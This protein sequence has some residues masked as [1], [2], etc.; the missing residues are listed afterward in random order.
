[1]KIAF[2]VDAGNITGTGHLMEVVSLIKSLGRRIEF[3]AIAI[4]NNYPLCMEKLKPLVEH[5]E[6][7]PD[8]IPVNNE[9]AILLDFLKKNDISVIVMDLLDKP[10]DYYR[11]LSHGIERTYVVLD[12]FVHKEIPAA[13]VVNFNIAQSQDYYKKAVLY[14]TEYLIGPKYAILDEDLYDIWSE[15]AGC[16][17][18]VKTIFVNQGGSDPYGLTVKSLEALESLNLQ[19]EII[20]VSGGAVTHH[21]KREL[22]RLKPLLKGN[23]KFY[24]NISQQKFFELLAISDIALTAAGNTLYEI[25]FFGIPS[26]VICHHEN[27]NRVASE[28]EKQ[29]AAINLGIGSTIDRKKILDKIQLLLMN[30]EKRKQLSDHARSLVDGYGTTRFTERIIETL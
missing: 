4:V 16:R 7:L 6:V 21:H 3:E 23:Y 5:I 20:V 28:F 17:D 1:M 27:H 14:D 15:K 10:V 12:N 8:E 11:A 30:R 22:E 24:E 9:P 18:E 2:R 29:G 19:Q 26:I 13:I 25:A